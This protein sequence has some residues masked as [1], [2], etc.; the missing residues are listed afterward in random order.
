MRSEPFKLEHNQTVDTDE[1]KME[2]GKEN[3]FNGDSDFWLL[4][5]GQLNQ[6]H[7]VSFGFVWHLKRTRKMCMRKKNF[8][9]FAIVVF[10][11]LIWAAVWILWA[12]C[13]TKGFFHFIFRNTIK[14]LNDKHQRIESELFWNVLKNFFCTFYNHW[15]VLI[16]FSF[17]FTRT[18]QR[19]FFF[20]WPYGFC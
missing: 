6:F 15:R 19:L 17:W 8:V 14:W 18:T 1:K 16:I 2:R 13:T 4:R 10:T 5:W 9:I 3:V 11:P 20:S 12:R 7:L